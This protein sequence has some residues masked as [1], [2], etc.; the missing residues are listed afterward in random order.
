MKILIAA[1]AAVAFAVIPFASQE[2][3]VGWCSDQ[4]VTTGDSPCTR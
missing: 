3:P 4:L 2:T 1:L